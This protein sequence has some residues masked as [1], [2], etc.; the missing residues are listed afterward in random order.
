[1][2][3]GCIGCFKNEIFPF[4]FWGVSP[5]NLCFPTI[6]ATFVTLLPSPENQKPYLSVATMNLVVCQQDI[7]KS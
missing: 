3:N 5:S 4:I 6:R 1:M 2:I 7:H